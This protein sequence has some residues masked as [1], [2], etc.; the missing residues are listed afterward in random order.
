MARELAI[1]R[2][3]LLAGVVAL[4]GC[5]R[6]PAPRS[7]AGGPPA[8]SQVVVQLLAEAGRLMAR[9]DYAAAADKYDAVLAHEPEH[10][11][12]RFG[13]GSAY[14]HLGRRAE[15]IEQFR[16]VVRQAPPQSQEHQAAKQWL[17]SVGAWS[18]PGPTPAAADAAAPTERATG[19][20]RIVGRTEWPGVNPK[21][22]FIRGRMALLR[23]DEGPREVVRGRPF[24][25]GDAYE[26]RDVQPGKYRLV[27]WIDRTIIWDET[28]S[29]E[30]GKVH[31]VV[32]TQAK[33]RIPADK[34]PRPDQ[35][36]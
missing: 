15:A 1:L 2:L 9:G 34:L 3:L 8:P 5:Q 12:G 7:A 36:G 17:I 30:P 32:L 6:A 4:L 14:S 16:W 35:E 22:L 10:V 21:D 18:E 33:S 29:V 27:A 26:F 28:V 23:D 31:E 13:L 11:T 20:G 25:L 19:P 24:R